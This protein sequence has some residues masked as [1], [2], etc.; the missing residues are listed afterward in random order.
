MLIHGSENCFSDDDSSPRIIFRKQTPTKSFPS[1]TKTSNGLGGRGV[2]YWTPMSLMYRVGFHS[3]IFIGCRLQ[4]KMAGKTSENRRL[5]MKDVDPS[6]D[7]DLKNVPSTVWEL[8]VETTS[9]VNRLSIINIPSNL[10][11]LEFGP[12]LSASL[13]EPF[14]L[15]I[16]LVS[17]KGPVISGMKLPP[18]LR[19]LTLLETTKSL[20]TCDTS[21]P[22]NLIHLVIENPLKFSSLD[23]TKLPATLE[24]LQIVGRHNC[25]L[26]K[27]VLPPSLKSFDVGK[28]IQPVDKLATR[29]EVIQELEDVEQAEDVFG[30]NPLVVSSQNKGTLR[31]KM[32][33]LD[34]LHVVLDDKVLTS[35]GD[36][37]TEVL[38]E[39]RVQVRDLTIT[40]VGDVPTLRDC[41]E[42]FKRS[43]T[44]GRKLCRKLVVE[45]E[46]DSHPAHLNLVSSLKLVGGISVEIS[47]LEKEKPS[48]C[49]LARLGKLLNL[50]RSGSKYVSD[51]F[52]AMATSIELSPE[53]KLQII[54]GDSPVRYETPKPLRPLT[55]PIAMSSFE[56]VS[57]AE[58]AKPKERPIVLHT[59][60]KC[61]FCK[62]Q[63]EAI[64]EFKKTSLENETRFNDKVEVKVLEDPKKVEDKRVNSF[65]TWVKNDKLIIGVQNVENLKTLI[66]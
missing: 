32:P 19:K 40:N 27:L 4:D 16:S 36:V 31:K 30:A 62:K 42:V 57:D 12:L 3:N 28:S 14:Y 60:T 24:T 26:E 29:V 34:K 33:R 54:V 8:E 9:T 50:T 66:E 18:N 20:Q 44:L 49:V 22:P 52:G 10:T 53:G 45:S 23:S 6:S 43:S 15:P 47:Y 59:W 56:G 1:A 39:G 17:Y 35:L 61:G 48:E 41:G 64:D 2:R 65:P 63:E 5:L 13:A 25:S 37:W 55:V 51:S 7:I 58:E 11:S 21:L 46:R 38:F